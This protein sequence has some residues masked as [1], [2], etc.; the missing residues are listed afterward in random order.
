MKYQAYCKLCK[1]TFNVQHT[2]KSAVAQHATGKLHTAKE[3]PLRNRTQRTLNF[4]NKPPSDVA[5]D[6]TV[7]KSS[8]SESCNLLPVP[9][10][11]QTS[12]LKCFVQ[13]VDVIK[14]EILWS[15]SRIKCHTSSRSAEYEG[16]LFPIM[17]PDSIIA[18]KYSMKK[19]KLSYV[20]TYGLAPYYQNELVKRLSNASCFA[21]SIDESLNK[22]CSKAQM[23][24]LVQF[25]DNTSNK[26]STRYLTS[27]FLEKCTADNMCS[28]LITAL[29]GFGLKLGNMIQISM[30]GPNVN[31]ALF[32]LLH[33]YLSNPDP[34]HSKLCDVGTCSVHIVHGAFGTGHKKAG[35]K[36][37]QFLKRS[38][39]LL[40]D[41]PSRRSDYK[42]LGKTDNFP[43]KFC[44]IRW[45]ENVVVLKRALLILEPMRKYV[46]EIEKLPDSCNFEFI[47][48]ALK[49]KLLRAKIE[50]MLSIA[51][52]L[53]DFLQKYQTNNPVFPFLYEDLRR[54]ITNI[55]D[56]FLK[57][58]IFSSKITNDNLKSD[59]EIIIG[60]GAINAI[61]GMKLSRILNF[62]SD[63]RTFLKEIFIK[64][65]SKCP[66]RNAIVKG[67]SAFSP[68]IMCNEQKRVERISLLL[69]AVSGDYTLIDG[70]AADRIKREYLK[71]CTSQ[72][73]YLKTFQTDSRL[74]EFLLK[75]NELE[76][77][78]IE[79]INFL[80]TIFTFFSSQAAV[81][82]SFSVNKECLIENLQEDSL[83]G[84]RIVYD[85]IKEECAMDLQKVD[86]TPSMVQYFKTASA[87]RKENLHVKQQMKEVDED[88]KRKL[89][90]ELLFLKAKKQKIEEQREEELNML[91]NNIKHLENKMR[92]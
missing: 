63:C 35:W 29:N 24:V 43:L 33:E 3:I 30:D 49:D 80:Q 82:R 92:T 1:K 10:S 28:T 86:I 51:E 56:R 4:L 52:D 84:Q 58:V 31:L 64:L 21:I 38:Y 90:Q 70:A 27:L 34:V 5:D 2:G 75:I 73:I 36:V 8:V 72:E 47:K 20:I 67:A 41:F 89:N 54:I 71:I 14:A 59:N 42:R 9:S 57:K 50:F 6:N 15:L 45:L 87:R 22:I 7:T 44:N 60:F 25:W 11:S 37:N 18:K 79:F 13:N 62:K 23:D 68:R 83:I 16:N 53:H 65:V 40:K 17:F 46:N 19:D 77:M 69:S 26:L 39:F 32:K 88:K 74:D 48:E 66:I 61:K 12:S 78:S 81:E 91:E 85:T 55:G 76:P